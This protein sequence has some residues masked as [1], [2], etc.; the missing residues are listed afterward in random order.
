MNKRSTNTA[1]AAGNTGRRK[2]QAP[3]QLSCELCRERKVKCDKRL[4]CTNCV[5]SGIVCVPI[6]RPRLPRGRHALRSRRTSTSPPAASSQL[7]ALTT[8]T[9]VDEDLNERIRRLEALVDSMG[10]AAARAEKADGASR[11]Q[12]VEGSNTQTITAVPANPTT[13][14][15]PS[16]GGTKQN[17]RS[18]QRPDD[19]WADLVEEIHGLRGVIELAK[20]DADEDDGAQAIDPAQS[21][22]ADDGTRVL[23]L[24]GSSNPH[25]VPRHLAANRA[26]L[27]RDKV[28]ISQLCQVYLRQVD[29]LIKILH[30]PSLSKWLLQGEGYLG[31]ADGHASVEA[32]NWAVCY[33]A[34][35]SMTENQCRTLFQ[36]GKSNV[37]AD[38]RR[39]SELA[40]ER[41]GLL[42]TRDITVLQ[43]FVLYLENRR[44]Q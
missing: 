42:T 44:P 13:S 6:Y 26:A 9:T 19:F 22:S 21:D 30:R 16:A 32:L 10:A 1:T 20:G 33:S 14:C 2:D 24:W 35:C 29:P 39:A 18:T 11:E 15:S 4:P 31:Y 7:P 12:S 25:P 5:S 41:S 40:M 3:P 34:A 23:G 37:V 36:A 8:T 43:A 27:S 38:C 17:S 28:A